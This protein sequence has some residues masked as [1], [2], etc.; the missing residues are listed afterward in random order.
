MEKQE[1]QVYMKSEDTLCAAMGQCYVTIEGRRYNFMQAIEVEASIKKKKVQ[2]PILGKPGKGNK[3]V[4]WEGSGKA[5]FHYNTSIFRKMMEDYKNTGKDVY[6]DMQIINEDKGS[7]VGRQEI[8]LIGCNLDSA[9]LAKFNA[10]GEYLEEDMDF[11]F[12]D[13]KIPV[14][15]TQLTGFLMNEKNA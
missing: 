10:D 6:F 4:G 9:I 13:F 7:G 2:V 15:F 3:S 8:M 1:T 5:K 11:T 12:E 14:E